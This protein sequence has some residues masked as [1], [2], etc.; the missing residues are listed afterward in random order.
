[1]RTRDKVVVV[2]IVV[3]L[4]LGGLIFVAFQ[5]NEVEANYS[6]WLFTTNLQHLFSSPAKFLS[7]ELPSGTVFYGGFS[8]FAAGLALVF[9]EMTRVGEIPTL[10]RRLM[11]LRAG[12]HPT[13]DLVKGSVLN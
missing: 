8:N 10:G 13:Q 3:S 9:L 11:G 7:D 4:I 1:M 6:R 12:K 2:L 5:D